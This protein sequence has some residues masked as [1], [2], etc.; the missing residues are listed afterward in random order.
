MNH[1]G[2]A[3]PVGIPVDLITDDYARVLSSNPAHAL[4]IVGSHPKGLDQVPWDDPN[5]D[6]LVFNEAPMKPEKYPRWDICLQ[7]HGPEV[8]A[9][10]NNWVNADYWPWLQD[11]HP[12]KTI[13]MQDYDSRV[14]EC[15]VY[16]LDGILRMIPYRYLRSSPAMALALGIY[17]RYRTIYLYGS[18]LS[19]N[20]EYSYQATNYAFWIG[21]AHGRGVD[22]QLRCWQDEFNQRIYGYEGELQLTKDFYQTRYDDARDA[23]VTNLNAMRQVQ[24]ALDNALLDNE[25]EKVGQLS[26]RLDEVASLTA[27]VEAAMNEAERYM[28]SERMVSRQEFERTSAQAQ[29]DGDKLR[30]QRDHEGGRVEYVWNVWKMTGQLQALQQLRVFLKNKFDL[31][32]QMGAKLG[33]YR[34]NIFYMLEYDARLTAAGGVR[35]LGRPAS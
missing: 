25:Y 30:S 5:I 32:Y 20:T 29:I 35:A 3:A 27:E 16:P 15:A 13:Y 12:G 8:Y 17:L 1:A 11:P 9:V 33:V 28:E 4:A 6:I 24:K 7:I 22:L 34:E 14:P 23:Y 21:Y 26:L 18:E 10:E 19:S 31:S 2:E